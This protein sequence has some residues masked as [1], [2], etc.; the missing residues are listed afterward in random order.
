MHIFQQ[1]VHIFSHIHQTY[2][3]SMVSA[4]E[5]DVTVTTERPSRW[6]TQEELDTA[7]LSTAMRKVKQIVITAIAYLL[8]PIAPGGA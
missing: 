1:V 4:A 8:M 6:L 5:S 7:A 3:V 2:Q